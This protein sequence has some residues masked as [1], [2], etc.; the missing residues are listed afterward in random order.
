VYFRG[1]V[2]AI[3][4]HGSTEDMASDE[5]ERRK[6]DLVDTGTNPNKIREL[7]EKEEPSIDVLEWYLRMIIDSEEDPKPKK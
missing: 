3:T 7:M 6:A 5:E 4:S 2:L 1:T